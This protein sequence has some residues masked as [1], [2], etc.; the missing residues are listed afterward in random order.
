MDLSP[1][2]ENQTER[3]ERILRKSQQCNIETSEIEDIYPCTPHQVEVMSLAAKHAKSCTWVCEYELPQGIE[4]EKFQSAW[5]AAVDANPILR[6]RIVQLESG[7]MYQVVLR[8]GIQWDSRELGD[9]IPIDWLNEKKPGQPLIRVALSISTAPSTGRFCFTLMLHHAIK[10]DRSL[11]LLLEQVEAAYNGADLAC[12]PFS[13]FIR[14]L[15]RSPDEMDHFW[16]THLSDLNVVHFPKLPS[17]GYCP[18]PSAQITCTIPLESSLGSKEDISAKVQLSWAML[19]SYYTHSADVVFGIVHSGRSAPVSGIEELT[20]PTVTSHPVRLLLCSDD[21]ISDAIGKIRILANERSPFQHAG[22]QRIGRIGPD[23]ASA[24]QYQSTLTIRP[25]STKVPAMFQQSHILSQDNPLAPYAL[26]LDVQLQPG[27][28]LVHASFDPQVMPQAEVETML[29]QLR[30]IFRQAELHPNHCLK[31][32]SLTSPEDMSRLRAWNGDLPK[33]LEVCVHEAIQEQCLAQPNFPAVSAWDGSFSYCELDAHSNLLANTLS[34]YKVGPDVFV[35]VYFDRTRWTTVAMLGVLKAGGALL[36]MDPSHPVER[37]REICRDADASIIL[38]STATKDQ[39]S[40]LGPTV[41]AVGDHEVYWRLSSPTAQVAKATAENALF[42]VFTSGSTGKPKGAV[43]SHRSFHTNFQANRLA[44]GLSQHSRVLQF[45]SHAFDMS[46]ADHLWALLVGGCICIPSLEDTRF[47]LDKAISDFKANWISLTPSVARTLTPNR[48]PSLKTL[49][50]IGEPMTPGDVEMWPSTVSLLNMYGPAECAIMTTLQDVRRSPMLNNIGSSR[51]A[52]CWIVDPQSHHRLFPINTVGELVIEGANVGRG[53]LNRPDLTEAA[54][55]EAPAWLKHFRSIPGR[56]YKT[57]DLVQYAADGSLNFKGRK[58][59]QVKLRGQRIELEEVAHNV[60][61]T[62]P[63]AKQTVAEVIRPESGTRPP[64]LVSF[65]LPMEENED[66]RSGKSLF[67]PA[68]GQLR[69]NAAIAISRLKNHIPEFMI[70]AIFIPLLSLPLTATGKLNRRLLREQATLLSWDDLAQYAEESTV[71]RA[72]FTDAQK[73]LQELFAQVLKLSS[74]DIGIDDNFFRLGGDSISASQ[75]VAATRDAG[76]SLT[77][78]DLFNTP[79]LLDL[80]EKLKPAVDNMGD[81]IPVFSLLPDHIR[82]QEIV[83]IIAAGA[84]VTPSQIEDVY[85]CTPMQEGLMALSMKHPGTY[86]ESFTYDLREEV[87]PDRFRAAFDSVVAAN[88]ILRTRMTYVENECFQAVIREE[89]PWGIYQS[90]QAF[91]QGRQMDPMGPNQRLVHLDLISSPPCFI[92]TMHHALYDGQSLP[93]LWNQVISAYQGSVLEPRPFNRFL[94]YLTRVEEPIEFWRLQFQNLNAPIFPG[95]PSPGYTPSPKGALTHTITCLPKVETEH[96]LSTYIR[97][98]WALALSQYTD[99]SDVVFGIIVDGRRVPFAG[100]DQVS[101]PTLSSYPLRVRINRDVSINSMLSNLQSQTTSAIPYEHAGL[102]NIRKWS[103]EAALACDFQCQLGVQPELEPAESP[104]GIARGENALDYRAFSSY[105]FVMVCHPRRTGNEHNIIVATTYDPEIVSRHEAEKI[106]AQFDYLLGHLLRHPQHKIQDVPSLRP[107]DLQQLDQWNGGLP[108]SFDRCLH[109]LVLG[110]CTTQPYAEAVS[111]WDGSWNYQELESLSLRLSLFLRNNGVVAGSIVPVCFE[112][113]KWAILAMLA[114]LRAG[115][116]VTAV[117][118]KHPRDRISRIV[119][120]AN[121]VIIL[122]SEGTKHIFA[123]ERVPVLT[124][125]FEG[126][127]SPADSILDSV[128]APNDP[129]FLVF[130]SGST[131]K[132]KG[133]VMEH[134]HLSTSIKY[135]SEPLRASKG[136]RGLHFASYAFDASIYEI[137]TVLCNGGCVCIPSEA[138]RLNG[139]EQFIERHSVNWAVF[140]PSTFRVLHPDRVPTLQTVVLGGEALTPD[141]ARQWG[142][143]LN[144]INGYGPAE[145]TICAAGRVDDDWKVGNIGPIT[146]GVGWITF[147]SDPNRLVPIGAI[148]E[149]IIEGPVVTRGYLGDVTGGYIEPPIWL[150]QFRKGG[151]GRVYRTGDLAQYTKDGS[152][153]FMGRRDTQVKLRGQRI[154]LSEVEYLVRTS[155]DNLNVVA[156]VMPVPGHEGSTML[157]AIIEEKN[158]I[159]NPTAEVFCPPSENF[160]SR[161]RAAAMQLERLVPAYMVP[162]VFL[163]LPHLPFTTGGKVDRKRLRQAVSTLTLEQMKAYSSPASS[164]IRRPSTAVEKAL[165]KIWADVLKRDPDSF[166]VEESFFSLGGDSIS[167]MQVTS[168]CSHAGL[169]ITVERIMRFKNILLLSSGLQLSAAA[170]RPQHALGVDTNTPFPLSPIQRLFLE[171]TN[172]KYDMFVRSITL[173]FQKPTLSSTLL[174]AIRL[175]VQ[176]HSMLRARF[177]QGDGGQWLQSIST[178]ADASFR[179]QK[180]DSIPS[181]A[182]ASMICLSS[183]RVINILEGPIFVIDHITMDDGQELLCLSAHQLVIDNVSWDIIITDLDDLLMSRSPSPAAPLPFSVWVQAHSEHGKTLNYPDSSADKL[184]FSKSLDY[185]G[186]TGMVDGWG[187]MNKTTFCIPAEQTKA[188][189]GGANQA[190][191]TNP[192]ELVHA[193]LLYSFAR[194]FPDRDLPIIYSEDQGRGQEDPALDPARTVGWFGDVWPAHIDVRG[195]HDLVEYVRRTKDGRRQAERLYQRQYLAAHCSNSTEGKSSESV[196]W[197]EVLFN[198]EKLVK[199]QTSTYDR[200]QK[201]Y[202]GF[203][204][205]DLATETTK[206][207][208]FSTSAAVSNSQLEIS[209]SSRR[210]MKSPDAAGIW[211]RACEEA[212]LKIASHLPSRTPALTLSDVPLLGLSYKQLD[213][214]QKHLS[215]YF[216][217]KGIQVVDA[218][219]CSPVQEGMLISQAKYSGDYMNLVPWRFQSRDGQAAVNIARLMRAWQQVIDKHPLLR[220]VFLSSFRDDGSIDQIVLKE[221]HCDIKVIQSFTMDPLEALARYKSLPMSPACPPHRLTICYSD[222]GE[223]AGLFDVSH[224]IIDGLSYQVL[225]RDLQ[226]AYDEILT[227]STD[228]AYRDYVNYVKVQDMDS[229]RRYWKQYLNGLEPTLFQSLHIDNSREAVPKGETGCVKCSLPEVSSL[230]A[231][232]QIHDVT[233]STVFQMA[234]AMVLKAYTRSDDVCFG[235]PTAGRD[236]AIENIHDAVGPFVNIMICRVTFSRDKTLLDLLQRCQEDFAESLKF[237]YCPLADIT[238]QHNHDLHPGSA[239]F[240]TALSIQKEVA[241]YSAPAASLNLTEGEMDAP[242]EYDAMIGIN[243]SQQDVGL[244]LQY[245]KSLWTD[246]Q[247]GYVLD[248]FCQAVKRVTL[249]SYLTAD[250]IPLLGGASEALV[251]NWNDN[252]VHSLCRPGKQTMSDLISETC[253]SQPEAPAVCAWDGEFTYT[254][255]DSLSGRL[256]AVLAV[257]GVGPEVFVPVCFEKS[258]WAVVAMLGIMRAGGAFIMMDPSQPAKRL[259]NICDISKAH[260]LI[261]SESRASLAA[262]LG[263]DVVVLG[264]N[265]KP[266]N[267]V[268]GSL[269]STPVQTASPENALYAVFTSGSTGTPKGVII[270]HRNYAARIYDEIEAYGLTAESRFLQFSSYAWDACVFEQLPVLVCGGCVC[271]PSDIERRQNLS[272]AVTRLGVN[273]AVFTP[274]MARNLNPDDFPTLKTLLIAGERVLEKE[275]RLWQGRNLQAL[276]GPAECTPCSARSQALRHPAPM[277][278]IG[279]PL[280]C[281]LWVA[282]PDN[283]EILLPIGATGELLIEGPQVSRGYLHEPEK[284]RAA[285]IEPPPWLHGRHRSDFKIYKTGDLVRHIGDGRLVYIGR[286]DTQVKVRGQRME[287]GEVESQLRQ[288]CQDFDEVV[289]GL[290]EPTEVDRRSALVAFLYQSADVGHD[291]D[292]GNADLTM[293]YDTTLFASAS[294]SFHGRVKDLNRALQ[295][296]LPAFMVPEFF[297]PL[298]QVPLNTS[299]KL[300]RKRLSQNAS[301]LSWEELQAYTAPLEDTIQPSTE[302][303]RQF[304]RLIAEVLQLPLERIGMQDSF[305]RLGGDSILAMTLMVKT[306]EAGYHITMADIF[307]HSELRDLA[308]AAASASTTE[309]LLEDSAL[310]PFSLLHGVDSVD[311]LIKQTAQTCNIPEASIED[312][313]PCTALQEGLMVLSTKLSGHYIEQTRYELHSDIELDRFKSAWDSTARANPILRTRIVQFENNT[314]NQVVMRDIPR[315]HHFDNVDLLKA[316]LATSTMGLGDALVDLS[317]VKPSDDSQNYLFFLTLHHAVYDGW[318]LQLLWKHVQSAYDGK[319]FASAPFNRYIRHAIDSTAGAEEFWAS[320]FENLQTPVF[321]SLPSARYVPTPTSAFE[322]AI[323]T[324]FQPHN[325]EYTLST[326]IQLAWSIVLSSYT[327]SDDVLFGMTVHGRNATFPEI[328]NT[329]GPTIATVPFRVQLDSKSPVQD[330]L[331]SLRKQATAMIPFEHLGLQRIGALSS[332]AAAACNFQCHIGIQPPSSGPISP[333]LVKSETSLHDSYSAFSNY[334]LV[335]VFHLSEKD[336]GNIVANVIHDNKVISSAAVKRM[337]YQFEHIL[338]QVI[339]GPE[340]ILDSLDMICPQDRVQLSEWHESLPLAHEDSGLHDL[341]LSHTA[342]QPRAS[343]VHAWDGVVSYLELDNMSLRLAKR[344]QALGVQRGSMVPLCLDRSKWVI[345]CMIAVMRAGGACV[346]LDPSHPTERMEDFLRRTE[347]KLVLTSSSYQDRFSSTQTTVLPVPAVLDGPTVDWSVPE[348]DPIDPAFIVFTSG[349]TGKPKGILMN[350]SAFCTSIRH[351]TSSLNI[352]PGETRGLHF[353]SYAFDASIYEIFSVLVNGGCVCIPS[354]ADRTSNLSGF[355]NASQVNWAIFTPTVLNNLLRPEQV[356]GLQTIIVGGEALT[357][358][359]VDIWADKV[360]LINGYGPAE[361]TICAAG[362]VPAQ[363]WLS[364]TIGKVTGGV[365]WV[366]MPSDP[367]RL[368]PIGAVG[369]LVMEG[370]VVTRGYLN[371][372]E[373]TADVYIPTPDWLKQFRNGDTSQAGRLYKSGDLVQYTDDGGIRFFGR[374]DTQVKLRGQRIELGEVEYQTARA[375]PGAQEVVAEVVYRNGNK[376]DATLIVFITTGAIEVSELFVGYDSEFAARVHVATVELSKQLPRYM[377]PAIFLHVSRV[378][379]TGSGKIDRRSLREQAAT[380][381]LDEFTRSKRAAPKELTMQQEHLLRDL[382]AETLQIPAEQIGADDNFFD[383]GGD[384]VKAMRMSNL[385]RQLGRRISLLDMFNHSTLSELA[386]ATE[387]SLHD[388]ADDDYHPGSLLGIADLESFVARFPGL[389]TALSPKNVADILPTTQLQSSIMDDKNATYFALPLPQGIDIDRLDE[390]CRVMVDHNPSLRTILVPYGAQY[391]QVILHRVDIPI[392]RLTCEGDDME[393]FIQSV[394]AQDY[395]NPI[396]AEVPQVRFYLISHITGVLQRLVIRA[397]HSLL[398]FVSAILFLKEISMAY[399]GKDLP[400][401]APSFARYLQYR[402]LNRPSDTSQFWRDYLHNSQIT[403]LKGRKDH[404]LPM[405]NHTPTRPTAVFKEIPLPIMKEGVTMATLTKAAW[406]LVLARVTGQDDVLFGHVLNGRELPIVNVEE[407]PGPC[408]TVSPLRVS[409]QRS[410]TVQ[411]LLRH[412]QQQYKRAMPFSS[413]EFYEIKRMMAPHWSP[414]AKLCSV[415]THQNEGVKRTVPFQGVECPV[416]MFQ[417]NTS[418]P[419]HVVTGPQ[420]DNLLIALSVMDPAICQEDVDDLAE[421]L[422]ATISKLAADY[423]VT[424]DF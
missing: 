132:P 27:D 142:P 36:L 231:F 8:E 296:T 385:A 79:K 356:P 355:I 369:E 104:L 23:P 236:V 128:V 310:L 206:F 68:D 323:S 227:S 2:S 406:A 124:A 90:H 322:H 44:L 229:A 339:E 402:L 12:Q 263:P 374:R 242:T 252:A 42:A 359:V 102:Q 311:L 414:D 344:L 365:G 285:F 226:L 380:R 177:S 275:I 418:T 195:D 57:G 198:F 54:F 317:I 103:H 420:G 387:Q 148:G 309:N 207:S 314:M 178:D 4:K 277:G 318:S 26:N 149:L 302:N 191:Q 75:L 141:I 194:V 345:I 118:L 295:Q 35:P 298:R 286:K 185:W 16:K 264:N 126:L 308:A 9:P 388:I 165:H 107:S 170:R 333:G 392:T 48:V 137:F 63:G 135:H 176:R 370:P 329:T 419:F 43:L 197:I 279:I 284:T 230:E 180:H 237:Q 133:I 53:Y 301:S 315:W 378:P 112:K 411:S 174:N 270:E 114:V 415:F 71:K 343:A 19:L 25:G 364:G 400:S 282:D 30:H 134:R 312:I 95:L 211:A 144:L 267:N 320:Q 214:F 72:A 304:Q 111:A 341:V 421:K 89:I 397:S 200:F 67:A 259:Q 40:Q 257:Q 424:I 306:R 246:T 189:L 416:E 190:F 37:L 203:S 160:R 262:T 62:F 362:R 17:P 66:P 33:G 289:V 372:P 225:L 232:C 150:K 106:V 46:V 274:P 65:V 115:G 337:I 366:T 212:L 38:A 340:T 151:P 269:V 119:E 239:L 31:D 255:L 258:R 122:A 50:L 164:Q 166:G 14:Y 28:L 260:V 224:A 216:T 130:T 395:T 222:N 21:M 261:A 98:A 109:E 125:P 188:L 305:F 271:I 183:H 58:D 330:C 245:H 423:S 199:R 354:E 182:D 59:N 299:G 97:L 169:Q 186:L 92:L 41:V 422:G 251:Q 91:L 228:H 76:Y 55:I 159:S 110:H 334:S 321:P 87:E 121:P 346:M 196:D 73:I 276:Y 45:A 60:Q 220:T 116:A 139:I 213:N 243:I 81:D 82:H 181:L 105:A 287:L 273:C 256:A 348:W 173:C 208:L 172:C 247:A 155:F 293:S 162:S 217:E 384:S 51:G 413:V 361:T 332:D 204:L 145:A 80:A 233:M 328:E 307:N 138:E 7:G 244:E 5:S 281:R 11:Q 379:R 338:N 94:A 129:A 253:M 368:A 371:D 78:A 47:N 326:M 123:S 86:V 383:L 407:V 335:V 3:V 377:V 93:V 336:K 249:N 234:W 100:I 218:Y 152:I 56:L 353:A 140:S 157:V 120:Q 297:V 223:V 367:S 20:G 381:N 376:H 373:K 313:Y 74:E 32:I 401:P 219:P 266:W 360:A 161:S 158:E 136:V 143:R 278:I 292:A 375:F 394:C 96:T 210:H 61:R 52:V 265:E 10:D 410:W 221:Y 187:D 13:T 404:A 131:G 113:S 352:E 319:R 389:P 39:A 34:D 325:S 409:I 205:D 108:S 64:V 290:I 272:E 175:L 363:G 331:F 347:A 127:L 193:A 192:E 240:N 235:Y 18:N 15:A 146:G 147:P 408:I 390:A 382:W 163:P 358:D 202:N 386:R 248:A 324:R 167:A 29:H 391:I 316:H 403:V 168:K 283:H 288:I 156:E 268:D 24:C 350:H 184:A 342:R 327:D 1:M 179:Y 22:L 300:D 280:S 417:H 215:T 69:E 393:E 357:Q 153:R 241:S 70:P 405:S 84:G 6:T 398:D 201:S 238:H 349:S 171:R 351:H 250:K 291:N 88:S 49:I 154:E 294:T 101:G 399:D 396:P 85:P 412:V 303:E 254:E 99:S 209:I 77:G 117:D 83:P